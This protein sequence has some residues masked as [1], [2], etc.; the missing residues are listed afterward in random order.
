MSLLSF[1][2]L[3]N[4]EIQIVTDVVSHWCRDHCIAIDSEHGR[5]AMAAAVDKVLSGELCPVT[6]SEAIN[7]AMQDRASHSIS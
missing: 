5:A 1:A 6:L 4:H 7:V 2:N 3:S